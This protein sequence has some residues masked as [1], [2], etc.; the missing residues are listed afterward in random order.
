LDLEYACY[1]SGRIQNSVEKYLIHTTTSGVL[2]IYIDVVVMAEKKNESLES[3]IWILDQHVYLL[4]SR[5]LSIL[6]SMMAGAWVAKINWSLG[7]A[8][9]IDSTNISCHRT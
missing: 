6:S 4:R 3:L 8:R 1:V 7:L 2:N 9:C 5:H